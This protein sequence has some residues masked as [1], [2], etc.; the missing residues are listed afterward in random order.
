MASRAR[1]T[2]R[3][4]TKF[5]AKKN[6]KIGCSPTA[7]SKWVNS[8]RQVKRDAP[9]N[10]LDRARGSGHHRGQAGKSN[11]AVSRDKRKRCQARRFRARRFR[12]HRARFQ[13][14]HLHRDSRSFVSA[15]TGVP[16]DGQ[17]GSAGLHRLP[18]GHLPGSGRAKGN[19]RVCVSPEPVSPTLASPAS[20]SLVA[21]SN[22][23]P[24]NRRV[25]SNSGVR[26]RSASAL[27]G[28]RIGIDAQHLNGKPQGRRTYHIANLKFRS[29][30]NPLTV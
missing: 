9:G 3:R 1:A 28:M 16:K 2:R 30:M 6:T 26:S 22:D 14:F 11:L 24:S 10:R 21:S 13:A 15:R 20:E 19:S 17:A 4:F 8:T 7:P 29:R 12:V 18:P 5:R 23:D 27:K 25:P